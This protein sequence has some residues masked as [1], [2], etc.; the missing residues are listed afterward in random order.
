MSARSR[1][2]PVGHLASR[3]MARLHSPNDRF[4]LHNKSQTLRHTK[5]QPKRAAQRSICQTKIPSIQPQPLLRLAKAARFGSGERE[6][7]VACCLSAST[8]G[9]GKKQLLSELE[10]ARVLACSSSSSN[11]SSRSPSRSSSSSKKRRL[12]ELLLNKPQRLL[13]V[14]GFQAGKQLESRELRA[15]RSD[16]AEASATFAPFLDDG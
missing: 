1:F 2:L 12:S 16:K 13:L 14:S 4:E 10:R 11:S 15:E 9:N 5:Q 7:D 8:S 6:D 3:F